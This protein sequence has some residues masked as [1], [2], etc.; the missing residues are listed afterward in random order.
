MEAA[1]GEQRI[2]FSEIRNFVFPLS[3]GT[4][5]RAN[6]SNLFDFP[7]CRACT[8]GLAFFSL[9]LFCFSNICSSYLLFFSSHAAEPTHLVALAQSLSLYA[10]TA[11]A[12]TT[13]VL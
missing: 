2:N 1:A 9:I 10:T 8:H 5:A 6:Q 11:V 7:L 3:S 13:Y 4:G 12:E